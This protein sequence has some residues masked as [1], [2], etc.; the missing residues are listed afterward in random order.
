MV[1]LA[2]SKYGIFEGLLF[3]FQ[4][5]NP[6]YHQHLVFSISEVLTLN[7]AQLLK[8]GQRTHD[9]KHGDTKLKNYQGVSHPASSNGIVPLALEHFGCHKT[10]H[11]K[12]GI[13][14][15]KQPQNQ[16]CDE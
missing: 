5:V 16:G 9:E 7:K 13:T 2:Y 3:T 12:R 15:G 6:S 10:G 11:E 8:Y 14:A 1:Y 4:T